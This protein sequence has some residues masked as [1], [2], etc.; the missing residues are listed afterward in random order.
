MAWKPIECMCLGRYR[1]MKRIGI[2]TFHDAD[3]FGC[4]LQCFA[5]QEA[6]KSICK[7]AEVEIINYSRNP[8]GSGLSEELKEEE[9]RIR[10][11]KFELFRKKYLNIHGDITDDIKMIDSN[12][13]DM[14]VV[15]SDQ[16]WNYNLV[17]GREEAYFLG[18]ASDK[19]RKISYAASLG[20]IMDDSEKVEW[21]KKWIV[22]MDAISIREKSTI[23]KV[24]SITNKKVSCCIDPTLLHGSDF[25]MKY[26]KKP[27]SLRNDKFI[28]MYALG[29]SW[30][31]E[32]ERKAAQMAAAIAMDK[33]YRVIH[34]YYGKLKEWL[35]DGSEHCYCEGPQEILWL[36]HH[37]EY[38]VCCSFHGTVFSVMYN[39]P[40]YTFY[41]PGNGSRMKDFVTSIG[42]GDRYIK[43]IKSPSDCDWNIMWESAHRKLVEI[44]TQSLNYLSSEL[45]HLDC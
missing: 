44:K 27:E 5:L 38:V 21:L 16:V 39:R 2:L 7:N 6:I 42:L 29:Y 12:R 35:P 8:V 13:Y 37:A 19:A 14:C 30:C 22:S 34:Y 20:S 25:W 15:G 18:F 31:R 26:E 4:V 43:D 24:E 17:Y 40:F 36:F 3:N 23:D 41:T 11:K 33:G 45:H 9:Q 1:V 32:E 10:A 28:L